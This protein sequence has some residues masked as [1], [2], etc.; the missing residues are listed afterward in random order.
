MRKMRR[1]ATIILERYKVASYVGRKCKA[2]HFA[3][4]I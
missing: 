1:G 2:V 4:K 3:M